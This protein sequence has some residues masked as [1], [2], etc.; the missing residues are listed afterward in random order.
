[1]KKIKIFLASSNELKEER[2]QFKLFIAHL[3]DKFIENKIY[4]KIIQWEYFLDA[5][6]ETRLQ[7]EYNKAL[8]KCDIA[9]CLFFTKVG[10]YSEEEFNTAYTIFKATGKPRIWTYFKDASITT[11]SI[12]SEINTL[13]AFKK[14]LAEL[15]HFFTTYQNTPDLHNKFRNQL[16]MVFPSLIMPSHL[17]PANKEERIVGVSLPPVERSAT[18]NSISKEEVLS[19]LEIDIDKALEKL[20]SIFLNKSGTYND[21]T[22]EYI[23]QP[24]NFS[25]NLFRNKL[26]RFL[27]V[28]WK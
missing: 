12:T 10:A 19:L 23:N 18:T 22:R 14:R 21:L 25:L 26:K 13:L 3:N 28:N 8:A 16:D 24:N 11:G 1:M 2:D 20:D 15:G 4:L 7:D 6:S 5:I 17:I 27:S 9:L